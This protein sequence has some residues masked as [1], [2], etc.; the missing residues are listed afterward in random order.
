MFGLDAATALALVD[1]YGAV[2]VFAVFALEG[3]LVGKV[4]PARTLFV[5]SVVAVGV[6]AIAVLP[7]FAAAVIGATVGQSAVFVAVRRFGVDP[8]S[9]PLVP[10]DEKRLDGAG[11]WFDRWGL[12]AV[13]ASNAVPG[14]RGWLAVPTANASSVSAPRFAVASLI[15]STAYVGALLAVGV[16]V[17]LGFGGALGLLGA[18]DVAAL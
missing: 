16:A 3:A 4:L 15:G 1:T 13:A 6:E 12:P 11:R 14:T 18:E 10:V 2:A 7:V 8:T 17:A 5:A 9:L